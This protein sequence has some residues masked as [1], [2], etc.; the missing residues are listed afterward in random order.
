MTYALFDREFAFLTITSLLFLLLFFGI[1]GP[2]WLKVRM[3][4]LNKWLSMQATLFFPVNPYKSLPEALKQGL[5]EFWPTKGR[6]RAASR[7]LL[8]ICLITLTLA[9]GAVLLSLVHL[10]S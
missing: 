6:L 1:V 2:N 5:K 7:L 10:W 4:R 8:W 9:L 3:R